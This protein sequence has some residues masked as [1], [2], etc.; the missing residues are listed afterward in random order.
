M[1]VNFLVGLLAGLQIGL[2]CIAWD[3]GKF[4]QGLLFFGI[5]VMLILKLFG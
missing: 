1:L 2:G 3:Q 4:W 5:A